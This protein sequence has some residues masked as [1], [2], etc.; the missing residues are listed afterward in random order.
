[1]MYEP[2]KKIFIPEGLGKKKLSDEELKEID[3]RKQKDLEF[4]RKKYEDEL[5]ER[6]KVSKID[7]FRTSF[8]EDHEVEEAAKLIEEHLGFPRPRPCG[9]HMAVKIYVRP[10]D[11]YKVKGED[12][13]ERT[14]YVP[15]VATAND[16]FRSCVGLVLAQGSQCYNK[17]KERGEE[18]WCK[19]GDWVV[20]ARN[21]GPQ[22]NY[23]GIPISY[24]PDDQIFD[25]V[26]DPTWVT[27]D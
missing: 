5:S 9:Y 6:S 16:K 22:V 17:V 13:V 26:A 12:G 21:A 8:I 1:M 10:E 3:E 11:M 24:I 20:F 23:R 4:Q 27:R 14:L 19:V 15:Q 2:Q 25:V 18:P 7:K